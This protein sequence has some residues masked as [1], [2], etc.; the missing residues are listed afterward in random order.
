M[1]DK[2]M[3]IGKRIL[4]VDDEPVSWI[5]ASAPAMCEIATASTFDQA[6]NLLETKSSIG[7]P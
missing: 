7:D 1:K 5:P 2:D 4:I 6:K 3:L